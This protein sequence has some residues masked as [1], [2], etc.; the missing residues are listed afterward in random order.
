MSKNEKKPAVGHFLNGD[1]T[2][3]CAALLKEVCR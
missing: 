1:F 2:G 3:V